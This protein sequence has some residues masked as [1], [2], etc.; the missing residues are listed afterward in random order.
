MDLI[1]TIL[2][3]VTKRSSHL[4]PVHAFHFFI[5][6]QV[7]HSYNS[8]TNGCQDFGDEYAYFAWGPDLGLVAAATL[9]SPLYTLVGRCTIQPPNGS[10]EWRYRGRHLNGS[11]SGFITESECLDS[12]SPAQLDVFHALWELYQPSRHRP[13]PAAKPTSSERLPANRTHA[14]LEVPI[15]TVVWRGFPDRQGRIQ[16]CRT[17]VDDYKT[18]Y[19]TVRHTDGD[20]EELTRT[21]IEQGRYTS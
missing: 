10:W 15:G 4:S 12:F 20:W 13:R 11:L 18:P 3:V 21:K 16:R 8:S 2:P 14:L 19:W 7:Q 1:I 17:E 9:A 5:A 6:M